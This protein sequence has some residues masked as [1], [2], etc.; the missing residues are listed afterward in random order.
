MVSSV[1]TSANYEYSDDLGGQNDL[2]NKIKN[3]RR[4]IHKCILGIYAKGKCIE[5]TANAF[6]YIYLRISA[7]NILCIRYTFLNFL[8]L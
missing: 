3:A 2:K 4:W 6:K 7:R 1:L 8:N 5:N